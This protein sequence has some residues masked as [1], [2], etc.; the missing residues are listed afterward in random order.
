MDA[1]PGE[2]CIEQMNEQTSD[3]NIH[4]IIGCS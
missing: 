1:D 4:R 3:Q 2:N